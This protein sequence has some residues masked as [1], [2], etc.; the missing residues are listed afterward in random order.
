[1]SLK[2]NNNWRVL[3]ANLVVTG[4]LPRDHNE[5]DATAIQTEYLLYRTLLSLRQRQP[6][7]IPAI[8]TYAA[9]YCRTLPCTVGYSLAVLPTQ[10]LQRI[11]YLTV[12]SDV[13]YITFSGH[14]E[15][16]RMMNHE[17]RMNPLVRLLRSESESY[18]TTDGQPV[19]LSWN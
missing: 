13:G 16:S 2:R 4:V 7:L 8:R 15:F 10:F 14:K 3:V 11:A 9:L 19:S 6:I 5:V 12:Q 1:V 17:S 18:V